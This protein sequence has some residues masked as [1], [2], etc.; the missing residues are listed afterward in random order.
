MSKKPK[1]GESP[2]R[3]GSARSRENSL[4]ALTSLHQKEAT[5]PAPSDLQDSLFV[6]KIQPGGSVVSR[7]GGHAREATVYG[8]R[9]YV[10]VCRSHL[11]LSWLKNVLIFTLLSAADPA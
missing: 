6:G 8:P 5:T 11:L 4:S 2:L 3:K 7:Q 10:C 9:V 1:T